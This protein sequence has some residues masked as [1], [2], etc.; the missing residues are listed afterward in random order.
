MIKDFVKNKPK[1]LTLSTAE[2]PVNNG[3]LN[4]ILSFLG[5]RLKKADERIFMCYTSM[6]RNDYWEKVM[7]K[8]IQKQKS[9]GLGVIAIGILGNESLLSSDKLGRDLELAKKSKTKTATI[10]RLG[11]LNKEYLEV[12]D[13]F[14]SS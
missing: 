7:K 5:V 10:F 9:V 4:F 13:K 1:N 11:G 2:Y 12:I 14:K 6:A 3:F 8:N